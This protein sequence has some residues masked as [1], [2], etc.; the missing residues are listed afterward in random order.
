MA[1]VLRAVVATVV[2]E[3]AGLDEAGWREVEALIDGALSGRPRALRRQLRLFLGLVEWL[4]TLRYGRPFTRLDPSRRA[5]VLAALQNH[6]VLKLRVGFW[7]LRTLALLGYYG[8]PQ[9]ARAIGYAA[10]AA[11]WEAR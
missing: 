8:R 11:G 7:G 10:S 2:P 1:S 3:A 5:R 9:A 6:R 4:P